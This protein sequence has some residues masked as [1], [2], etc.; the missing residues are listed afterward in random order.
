VNFRYLSKGIQVSFEDWQRHSHLEKVGVSSHL[1]LQTDRE[2][3]Q[4][5]LNKILLKIVL[6]P[7]PL[8]TGK[9]RYSQAREMSEKETH[10]NQGNKTS[11]LT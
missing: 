4:L 8:S 7:M 1:R 11:V 9:T 6:V 5:P 10:L 3:M 2:D